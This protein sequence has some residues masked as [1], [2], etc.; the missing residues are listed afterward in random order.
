MSSSMLLG[1]LSMAIGSPPTLMGS[2]SNVIAGSAEDPEVDQ[3]AGEAH[4]AT[5][6]VEHPFIFLDRGAHH[7]DE[8]AWGQLLGSLGDQLADLLTLLAAELRVLEWSHRVLLG[9]P[10]EGRRYRVVLTRAD[11]DPD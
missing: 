5:V 2:S 3:A 9:F 11:S 4:H 10:R 7:L 8:V 6:E 1:S